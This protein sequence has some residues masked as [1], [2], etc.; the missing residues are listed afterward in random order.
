MSQ[1]NQPSPTQ[2]KLTVA[3]AVVG[4]VALATYLASVATDGS[5]SDTLRNVAKGA[6]ILCALLG[7]SFALVGRKETSR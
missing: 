7:V 1:G 5:T 6:G 2:R 3:V 4:I